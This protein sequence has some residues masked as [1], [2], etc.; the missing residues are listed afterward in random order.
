MLYSIISCYITFKKCV[1]RDLYRDGQV[2]WQGEVD[3]GTEGAGALQGDR[4]HGDKVVAGQ[5]PGV[6]L[7]E[8]LRHP[9]THPGA[10]AG[11]VVLQHN[12]RHR[13][14]QQ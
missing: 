11:L 2:S 13:S 9:R 3:G 4:G 5:G 6:Q 7:E 12:L 8:H 14:P 1:Q 10:Q